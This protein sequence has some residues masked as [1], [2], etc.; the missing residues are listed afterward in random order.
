MNNVNNCSI[1]NSTN[2][3]SGQVLATLLKEYTPSSKLFES[4]A[5]DK[6][7]DVLKNRVAIPQKT[8]P[9][10]S[11]DPILEN[12]LSHYTPSTELFTKQ[13]PNQEVDNTSVLVNEK[14]EIQSPKIEIQP[15]IKFGSQ[16]DFITSP[17]G[18][19]MRIQNVRGDGSCLLHAFMYPLRKNMGQDAPDFIQRDDGNACRKALV[20]FAESDS[21]HSNY[22]LNLKPNNTDVHDMTNLRTPNAY[23]TAVGIIGTLM[24]EYS[25]KPVI[26]F[27]ENGLI[28]SCIIIFGS[29]HANSFS[30]SNGK[31]LLT[32]IEKSLLSSYC[33]LLKDKEIIL[34]NTK[35]SLSDT[36]GGKDTV[37]KISHLL[38]L[39]Q[40]QQ[41]LS[42]S[43]LTRGDGLLRD[44][45][46]KMMRN[47]RQEIERLENELIPLLNAQGY[48]QCS[49][50]LPD[51]QRKN[52]VL[53][54][55]YQN[56][57]EWI[58]LYIFGKNK[59][60]HYQAVVRK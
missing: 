60:A 23:A 52:K 8:E 1:Y 13:S 2:S 49:L 29:G 54:I 26:E 43:L 28:G 11:K 19:N 38:G 17:N 57:N 33:S 40:A 39:I 47:D 24:A 14:A 34:T 37:N 16:R 25:G 36:T 27:N 18:L 9:I 31:D 46:E 41:R 4:C 22:I 56:R 32:A 15:Q 30:I 50:L 21:L 20:Q 12:L 10:Q 42:N 58:G 45:R 59:S 51:I 35:E 48:D 6:N 55:N 53:G 7:D 44:V 3:S 5:Q